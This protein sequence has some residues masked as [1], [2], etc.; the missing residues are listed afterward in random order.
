MKKPVW[1]LILL[2]GG[3]VS[4]AA[5]QDYSAEEKL[6]IPPGKK[7]Q[8]SVVSRVREGNILELKNGQKIRLIGVEVPSSSDSGIN[9]RIAQASQLG[10][11][12]VQKFA[13]QA[14][15]F[16]R[17][18]VEGK[19]V[20]LEFDEANMAAKHKDRDGRL[21][22]YVRFAVPVYE[23][24][25]NGLVVNTGPRFGRF[26]TFLNASLIKAGYGVT[27]VGASF[28]YADEFRRYEREARENRRGLW[29]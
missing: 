23:E 13:P 2:L 22:A 12:K 25:P 8:G 17:R 19:E 4:E 16:V 21:L 20:Q 18:C 11:D 9:R 1:I 27:D 14:L 6:K 3:F 10:P 24:M 5:A 7:A 28:R 26:D 29:A 15:R